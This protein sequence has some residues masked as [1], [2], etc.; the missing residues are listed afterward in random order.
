MKWLEVNDESFY[1]TLIP[2]MFRSFT[3]ISELI[4]KSWVF[5]YFLF[6]LRKSFV[7]EIDA[8]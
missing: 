5:D 8:K 3:I 1:N 2:F 7:G 4:R 6:V